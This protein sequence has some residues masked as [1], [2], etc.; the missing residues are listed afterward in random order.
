MHCYVLESPYV[1]STFGRASFEVKTLQ[2]KT[3]DSPLYDNQS[4][5]VVVSTICVRFTHLIFEAAIEKVT[6]RTRSMEFILR[7]MDR[8]GRPLRLGQPHV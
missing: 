7:G 8:A 3:T 6:C 1:C 4:I 5:T 2:K